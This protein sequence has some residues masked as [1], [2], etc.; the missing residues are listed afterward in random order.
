MQ[1]TMAPNV[2]DNAS[3]AASQGQPVEFD[4]AINYFP[5]MAP[6]VEDNAST[7]ASQGQPVEFD[8]AINYVTKIKK[9]FS[10]VN[11][12]TY[13]SFLD[14]LHSYQ[15]EQ[16]S[17]PKI[18]EQV[19]NLF[20]DHPD[21]LKDFTQFLPSDIRESAVVELDKGVWRLFIN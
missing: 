20:K 6:N 21:L 15:N 1:P 8:H 11:D 19:S 12:P 9:R 4:H 3:T 2:E 13:K 10:G 5:A 7:A 18:L 17:L 14:I 16:H